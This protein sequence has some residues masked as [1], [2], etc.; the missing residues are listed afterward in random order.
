MCKYCDGWKNRYLDNL[1]KI[2]DK[3]KETWYNNDCCCY[4]MMFGEPTLYLDWPWIPYYSFTSIE[5]SY[6]PFC[7]K[8]LI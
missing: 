5:I 8:K 6:C 4:I 2:K 3:T 1:D 7:G